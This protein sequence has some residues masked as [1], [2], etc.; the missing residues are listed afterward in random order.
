MMALGFASSIDHGAYKGQTAPLGAALVTDH[1]EQ[2][3]F[4]AASAT[5]FSG[6][7]SSSLERPPRAL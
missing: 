5:L 2:N 3:I 1:D 4:I 6:G 7:L